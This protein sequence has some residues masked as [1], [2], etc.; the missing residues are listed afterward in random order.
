MGQILLDAL[1]RTCRGLGLGELRRRRAAGDS[2]CRR[3][4]AR[5]VPSRPKLEDSRS[6]APQLRWARRFLGI[7][8]RAFS[9]S[10]GSSPASCQARRT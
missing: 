6:G 10:K 9:A 8:L 4:R 2:R 5:E 7:V 1:G 3:H